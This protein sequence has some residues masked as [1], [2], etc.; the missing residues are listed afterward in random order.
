MAGNT[1]GTPAEKRKAFRMAQQGLAIPEI[2]RRMG[3][4]PRTVDR[5]VKESRDRAKMRTPRMSDGADGSAVVREGIPLG[6]IPQSELSDVARRALSDFELFRKRYLGHVSTPWQ[7]EAAEAVVG[8]LETPD[9]EYLALNCPPGVGKSTLIHDTSAWVTVRN[10]R[11]RGLNGSRVYNNAARATR[12]LR[13]TLERQTPMKAQ[14]DHVAKGLAVD[15]E[16]CLAADYGLF[17]PLTRG[18]LW[19]GEEFIVVQFDDE[20]IE[21][22]EPTW[23]SYGQDSGALGNRFDFVAWDDVVDKTSIRTVEAMEAQREWW[24]TEGETRLEPGGLLWLNGQ[25]MAASDLYRYSLDKRAVP[26]DAEDETEA[27]APR[28]YHHIVF[29]AHDEARCTGEH[30]AL[31]PWPESCLLDPV[32][33]PWRELRTIQANQTR[34]RV[35]YQQED[36]D[37]DDV[38]VPKVWISGGTDPMSGELA[39]GCND[40]ERG[41]CEML[42]NVTLP[43]YS[44]A[45]VDPSGSNFWAVQWWVYAP[46]AAHQSFLMD[47]VRQKMPAN[48]LLDWNNNRAEFYGLMQ[49][50]QVRSVALGIP[51]TAWIVEVNAAQ[52]YLLTY[53]HIHRWQAEHRT[54]VVPHSTSLT[55]LDP[56]MGVW[57]IRD[58]FRYG[59][60]RLPMKG[61]DARLASLKL[62]GEVTTWPHGS[63]DDEVMASWF[64]FYNLPKLATPPIKQR[65]EPRPSWMRGRPR[66]LVSA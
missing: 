13:R 9:K 8:F 56:D 38:L 49:E 17:R 32:R 20:P 65:V 7:T 15:A 2:A 62:V 50:W 29:K 52:R 6:P 58:N 37:P 36:T 41:L 34:Y 64:Y 3:R 4:G 5:W 30:R 63:Q 1:W 12:R 54:R 43:W 18:D 31:P 46:N 26:D 14:D 59:R 51:I 35:L 55:K 25:R 48:M 10:R 16:A 45:T 24:D 66:E 28:K 44:I 33:L 22:K 61:A 23:S 39:P 47:L 57:S 60:V 40:T 19:R 27:D 11:I 21:E 53:D 42:P